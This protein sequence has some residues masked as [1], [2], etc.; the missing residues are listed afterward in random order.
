MRDFEGSHHNLKASL[1]RVD[2]AVSQNDGK[3]ADHGARLGHEL[4][5]AFAA[6]QVNPDV[7]CAV[8]NYD[9]VCVDA[10]DFC[11]YTGRYWLPYALIGA[12]GKGICSENA[13]ALEFMRWPSIASL[14]QRRT[15]QKAVL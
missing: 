13:V 4:H 8:D 3:T 9:R 7:D 11:L 12:S 15:A 10:E 2:A 5:I 6:Q 1:N 14:Q